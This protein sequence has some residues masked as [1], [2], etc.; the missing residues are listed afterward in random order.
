MP[1]KV[2]TTKEDIV[3]AAVEIVRK[4]G[5]LALNARTIASTLNISTQ[6]I[7][8]NFSTME[9]L[10]YAVIVKADELCRSYMKNEV[11]R[12][13]YP[14]Y[15][16]TGIAYIRFA[17]EEKELFKLLYMRDRSE[18][19]FP[20]ELEITEEM[21]DIV[22]GNTGLRGDSVKIF[23][24]EMWAYVH[25]IAVMFATGFL[26]LEWDLVSKMLTDSYQGLRKQYGME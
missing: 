26:D 10:R 17:K 3:N 23:H 16:S 15:K 6:P 1:P 14:A 2:K 20:K 22:R 19:S 4:H 18:E 5:A 7:F 13:E 11:E 21:E 12:G 24:L 25:G 9:E 8:S